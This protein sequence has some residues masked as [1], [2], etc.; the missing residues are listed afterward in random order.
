M[1]SPEGHM[2]DSQVTNSTFSAIEVN[3]NFCQSIALGPYQNFIIHL[4]G[5]SK[6]KNELKLSELRVFEKCDF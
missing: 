1:P 5:L 2:G 4:L 3:G 6:H